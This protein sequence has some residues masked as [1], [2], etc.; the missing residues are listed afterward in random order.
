MASGK[1]A[2]LTMKLDDTELRA[3]FKNL[4]RKGGDVTPVFKKLGAYMAFR[5][6][7]KT[8]EKRGRPKWD[9]LSDFT[10]AMRDWRARSP[11][12]PS[13]RPA[14]SEKILEV[15]GDLRDSF[16]F[17]ACPKRLDVGTAYKHADWHQ[18][19]HWAAAPKRWERPMVKIPKRVLIAI[20]PEDRKKA[21]EFAEWQLKKLVPG[22]H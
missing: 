22:A 3:A 2:R 19:G 20:Y 13:P 1:G 4:Y 16:T 9:E 8:F 7:D 15:T 10:L 12:A 6:V 18:F 14:Y 17:K 11:N 21:V 5:S